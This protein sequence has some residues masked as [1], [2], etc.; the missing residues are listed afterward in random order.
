MQTS[1]FLVYEIL[2]YHHHE[3]IVI[4]LHVYGFN[5]YSNT[6]L[7]NASLGHKNY[8]HTLDRMDYIHPNYNLYNTSLGHNNYIPI[9][10]FKSRNP[11]NHHYSSSR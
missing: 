3:G 9:Y 7:N 8:N 11:N 10:Y 6:N 2:D 5:H 4:G 1:I